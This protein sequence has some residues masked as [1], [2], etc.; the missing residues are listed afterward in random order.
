MSAPRPGLF[1][2]SKLLSSNFY[3]ALK[4]LDQTKMTELYLKSGK[5]LAYML[6]KTTYPFTKTAI[7]THNICK[8]FNK[9]NQTYLDQE[10]FAGVQTH[11]K[12]NIFK[13]TLCKLKPDNFRHLQAYH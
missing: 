13:I 7:L 9:G 11:Q 8:I 3:I 6:I 10:K 5:N 2:I 12:V 1:Q 4:K